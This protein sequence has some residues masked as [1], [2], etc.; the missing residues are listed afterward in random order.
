MYSF[1]FRIYPCAFAIAVTGKN[2]KKR[3]IIILRNLQSHVC[4][5]EIFQMCCIWT[6][7]EK[8][9]NLHTY[10]NELCFSENKTVRITGGCWEGCAPWKVEK[11]IF[12][13]VCQIKKFIF[14]NFRK[15]FVAYPENK[16]FWFR[17]WNIIF[18]GYI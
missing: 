5:S 16:K 3:T 17:R 2:L 11:Q 15:R 18:L 9:P 1:F 8:S 10:Q 6:G 7:T 12:N 4:W 14:D 13:D